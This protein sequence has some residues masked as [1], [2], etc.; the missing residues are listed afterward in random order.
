ML[1]VA[2]E[3]IAQEQ[4]R[5]VRAE[6]VRLRR[7]GR[8]AARRAARD[9]ERRQMW[10]ERLATALAP[11][12]AGPERIRRVADALASKGWKMQVK[13][14]TPELEA[15][16]DEYLAALERWKNG[17]PISAGEEWLMDTYRRVRKLAEEDPAVA[18]LGAM[19][20]GGPNIDHL[21]VA[22][23]NILVKK[24][25]S[26]TAQSPVKPSLARGPRLLRG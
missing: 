19:S 25:K 11:G 18:G 24:F 15:L 1:A 6:E 5:E 20:G 17:Q 12:L 22:A 14:L 9:R 4:A 26:D 3:R 7:E 16:A 10:Q 13:D 2:R 8:T 21:R 23:L